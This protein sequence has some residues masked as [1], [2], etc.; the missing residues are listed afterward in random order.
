M[1]HISSG[2]SCEADFRIML[3]LSDVFKTQSV[4]KHVS[5]KEV[6][7]KSRLSSFL[8]H[9]TSVSLLTGSIHHSGYDKVLHCSSGLNISALIRI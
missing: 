5:M 3:H 2:L 9:L 4:T 1:R 7:I 8:V 6:R